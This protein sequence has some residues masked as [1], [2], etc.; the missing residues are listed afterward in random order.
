MTDGSRALPAADSKPSVLDIT[1]LEPVASIEELPETLDDETLRK[2]LVSAESTD[3]KERTQAIESLAQYEAQ[4][5]VSALSLLALKDSESIV[6]ALAIGSLASINHESIFPAVLIGMADDSRE[7][8][9]AA[10]RALSR[11]RFDRSDAYVRVIELAD[12]ASLRTVAEACIKAGIVSQNIDRLYSNDRRHIYEAFCLICL[13][14]KAG[15]TWPVLNAIREHSNP[16]VRLNA[17]HLLATTGRREV[18]DELRDLTNG[19]Q[20]SE[21][22]K[23]AI[24]ERLYKL[25]QSRLKAEASELGIQES[26]LEDLAGK[27]TSDEN[28]SRTGGIDKLESSEGKNLTE[29]E[30]SAGNDM[31]AVI[32]SPRM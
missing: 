22:M 15:L 27:G 5:A 12:E 10:A 11:L 6:R 28:P 19:E 13:L 24:I 8:R 20:V 4:D 7:V 31:P 2:A 18:L 21:E 29:F 16:T 17:V 14:A 3:L 30:N 26:E 1:H 23:T 9:A 32:N 25:E